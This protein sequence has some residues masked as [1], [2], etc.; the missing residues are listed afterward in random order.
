[1]TAL[2]AGPTRSLHRCRAAG[3]PETHL[4]PEF[5]PNAKTWGWDIGSL[6]L[7]AQLDHIVC[8]EGLEPLDAR[9][10][11]GGRSDH[12]PVIASFVHEAPR[13]VK[14]SAPRGGSLSMSLR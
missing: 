1:L 10:L 7:S 12:Q 2:A 3:A 14:L 9:V 8:G 6:H 11:A 5:H 4:L 13:S